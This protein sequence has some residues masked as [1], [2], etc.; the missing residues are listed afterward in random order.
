VDGNVR[1]EFA[2][3]RVRVGVAVTAAI[4]SLLLVL[5]PVLLLPPPANAILFIPAIIACLAF[6]VRAFRERLIVTSDEV[7]VRNYWR[8]YRF[9][10]DSVTRVETV[11]ASG[12]FGAVAHSPAVVFLL[13]ADDKR[14][15]ALATRWLGRAG[16]E[17]LVRLVRT[18]SSIAQERGI[19]SGVAA[20]ALD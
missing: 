6:V 18:L 14:V 19:E 15:E 1:A 16:K 9:A 8:T 5:I 2:P 12:P 11:R 10:W 17:R 4:L 7:V 13:G 20:T 3:L